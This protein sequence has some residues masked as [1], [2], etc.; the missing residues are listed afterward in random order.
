MGGGVGKG[1]RRWGGGGGEVEREIE[2]VGEG[3]EWTE[4]GLM[5]SYL[6]ML[7]GKVGSVCVCVCT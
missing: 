5:C 2:E 6:D 4:V 7:V 1:G 3:E